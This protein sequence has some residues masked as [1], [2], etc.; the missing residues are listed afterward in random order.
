MM[1]PLRNKGTNYAGK[2]SHC[3]VT[4]GDAMKSALSSTLRF[5]SNMTASVPQ[6]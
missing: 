5:L 6:Y 2:Q 4:S 3:T 1:E